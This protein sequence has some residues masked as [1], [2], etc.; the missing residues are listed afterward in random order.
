MKPLYA[1]RLYD[2][3]PNDRIK[4]QCRLCKRGNSMPADFIIRLGIASGTKVLDLVR[5]FRCQGCKWRGRASVSI[6]W[7]EVQ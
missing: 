4:V 1:A 5:L 6:E 3:G 2:L 7:S